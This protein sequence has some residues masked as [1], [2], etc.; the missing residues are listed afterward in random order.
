MLSFWNYTLNGKSV[1]VLKGKNSFGMIILK[2][3][4]SLANVTFIFKS[5]QIKGRSNYGVVIEENHVMLSY[6][7]MVVRKQQCIETKNKTEVKAQF[8]WQK[9]FFEISLL[10]W[11]YHDKRLLE[12]VWKLEL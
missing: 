5:K 2:G 12:D 1:I 4:I 9:H 11:Y 8:S 7:Y 6:M 10:I 3:W